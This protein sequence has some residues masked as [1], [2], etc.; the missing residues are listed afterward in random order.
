MNNT[1]VEIDLDILR[2]NVKTII[3][4]YNNYKYYFGVVKSNAYGHGE[5]IVNELI[6]GGINYIAVSYLNE[7]FL[8]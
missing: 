6:K 4:K 5:Y 7:A 2:N 8:V 1:Y 3:E